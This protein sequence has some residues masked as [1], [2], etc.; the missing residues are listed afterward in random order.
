VE[1]L[2]LHILDIAENSLSAGAKNIMIRLIED[3]NILTL[4][5]EDDGKGMDE[6]LLRNAMNP[7]YTTKD[8]KKFGLGLALLAQA[9]SEAGGSMKIHK[10]NV[11]GTKIIASF[12]KDNIDIKP[13]GNI[14]RT[15][16]VLIASHP[17]VI[18]NFKH[19]INNGESP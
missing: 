15:M 12:N 14:E 10:G 17:E 4:E 2:S 16:R 5:I 6:K 3:E 7:F 18:F 1:D 9:A 11:T 13:M 19:I 8:G